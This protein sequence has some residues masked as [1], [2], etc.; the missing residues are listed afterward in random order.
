MTDRTVTVDGEGR[1]TATATF[2][3]VEVWVEGRADSATHARNRARDAE[4][5]V[6][7]ALQNEEIDPEEIRTTSARIENQDDAFGVNESDPDHR[8]L[9]EMTVDC[10]PE[11]AGDVVTT[12]TDAAT[13]TGIRDVFFKVSEDTQAKLRREALRD[14]MTTAREDAEAIAAP[15]GLAVGELLDVTTTGGSDGF[16]SIVDDALAEGPDGF[17]PDPIEVTATVEATFE[18]VDE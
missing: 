2:A 17:E 11:T 6:R 12:V 5:S 13:G 8:A 4:A 16:E 14:A 15:E 7:D 1:A 18:L 10:R 9:V 3:A